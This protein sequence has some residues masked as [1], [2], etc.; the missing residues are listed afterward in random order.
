MLGAEEAHQLIL[1]PAPRPR[2]RSP[3]PPRSSPL[4]PLPPREKSKQQQQPQQEDKD[5]E[6]GDVSDYEGIRF[7]YEEQLPAMSRSLK[8]KWHN[9]QRQINEHTAFWT[10]SRGGVRVQACHVAVSIE[11]AFGCL[12]VMTTQT[13]SLAQV[14]SSALIGQRMC[15]LMT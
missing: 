10:I 7:F 9:D 12:G 15:W 13:S 6:A 14:G 3:K 4:P 1:S 2:S 8:S 11:F 5:N